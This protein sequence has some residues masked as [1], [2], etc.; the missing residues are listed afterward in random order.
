[1]IDRSS[2]HGEKAFTLQEF[3]CSGVI[4]LTDLAVNLLGAAGFSNLGCHACGRI[5][6]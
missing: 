2:W 1:V 6:V 5:D 3:P 4:V